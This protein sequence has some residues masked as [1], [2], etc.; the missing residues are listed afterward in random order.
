MHYFKFF[1]FFLQFFPNFAA[2]NHYV[3][4]EKFPYGYDLNAYIDKA[5]E[6]MRADFPWATRDMIAEHTYYGIEKVGDDYQYVRYYSYCSPDILNVDCEE[7]IRRLT[8]DHDWEL[9]T[10]NPV[11]EC[12]DVEAFNRCS[13]DWFLE[14]YQIQKHEKGGYSV[15]VTAGNR[16]AGGSKTVFIPASYFKLSWQE[17]LD[18]YLDL[19]IPGSFYVGRADLERDPRIKE[20]LGF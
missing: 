5:F 4:N 3:M 14:C 6:Q 15:Y 11:K 7:F 9:E 18:K 17:F 12:I 20:F 1:L 8:L 2:I 10:A 16:S 13:G 19:A